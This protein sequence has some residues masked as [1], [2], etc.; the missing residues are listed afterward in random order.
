MP[1]TF[2]N[3]FGLQQGSLGQLSR[4]NSDSQGPFH[5]HGRWKIMEALLAA[6]QMPSSVEPPLP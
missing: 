1:Y 2:Q 6:S 3:C 4:L 5:C